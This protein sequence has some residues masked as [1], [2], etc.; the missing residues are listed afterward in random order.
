MIYKLRFCFR[1]LY[2]IPILV[3]L[4]FIKAQQNPLFRNAERIGTHTDCRF[5]RVFCCRPHD[6][7]RIRTCSWV[8]SLGS[9]AAFLFWNWKSWYNCAHAENLKYQQDNKLS[10]TKVKHVDHSN[11]PLGKRYYTIVKVLCS[12][13]PLSA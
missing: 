3:Y 8:H 5:S 12:L 13:R 4:K 1:Y 6:G 9:Q 11:G 10:L 7:T 2:V